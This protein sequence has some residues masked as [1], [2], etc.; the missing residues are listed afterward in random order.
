MRSVRFLVFRVVAVF[1]VMAVF[2]VV[3]VVVVVIIVVVAEAVVPPVAGA[4]AE[5]LASWPG[6]RRL[7]PW[8]WAHFSS[9]STLSKPISLEK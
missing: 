6:R 7:Q 9:F 4:T 1:I 2:V 8:W 3:V 5:A